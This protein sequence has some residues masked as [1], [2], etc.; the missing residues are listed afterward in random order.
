MADN[1]NSV[2]PPAPDKAVKEKKKPEG[3]SLPV[4][5]EFIFT[6]SAILLVV[7]FLIIVTT[8]LLMGAKLLDIILRTGVTLLV[9][10][11]L[12]V[13]ISRQIVSGMLIADVDVE[14]NEL[15]QQ[16]SEGLETRTAPEVV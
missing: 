3:G 9:I 11:A 13:L 7:L 15:A 5:V 16:K 1:E 12:L 10:G 2:K 6:L 14:Q 8:S 4:L